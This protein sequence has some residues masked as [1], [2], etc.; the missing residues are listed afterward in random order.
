MKTPDNRTPAFDIIK[1]YLPSIVLVG[2][3]FVALVLAWKDIGDNKKNH[4]D[5][6]D[7]VARQYQVQR[8][9]N[10]KTNK[11]VDALKLESAYQRGYLDAQKEKK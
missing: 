3:A 4:Q 8:E 7:Q 5:L 2:G 11:E 6:R 10:E 1:N 9:M